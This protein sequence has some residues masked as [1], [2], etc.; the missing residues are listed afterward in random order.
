MIARSK[1]MYSVY[2]EAVNGLLHHSGHGWTNKPAEA[3]WYAYRRYAEEKILRL[4]KSGEQEDAI[5]LVKASRN[6]DICKAGGQ[7]HR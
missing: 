2:K 6:E 4:I 3:R 7:K 1:Y 5:Q